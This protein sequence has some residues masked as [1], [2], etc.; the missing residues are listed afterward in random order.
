MEKLLPYQVKALKLA[1]IAKAVE[2]NTPAE[3][4]RHPDRPARLLLPKELKAQLEFCIKRTTPADHPIRGVLM[5]IKMNKP[6]APELLCETLAPISKLL[7]AERKREK[8]LSNQDEIDNRRS[9]FLNLLV[10][11]RGAI[12][13]AA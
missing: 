10:Y 6:V 9:I 13:N 11:L 5:F 12:A 2:E 4:V 1:K 3:V 8:N 7:E